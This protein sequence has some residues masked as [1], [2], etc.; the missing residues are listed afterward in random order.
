MGSSAPPPVSPTM[1]SAGPP[2][3]ETVVL[4]GG[5]SALTVPAVNTAF[6]TVEVCVHGTTNCQKI[7]HVEIDTGS[8]GLR[9]IA[10]G[11]SDGELSLAL[12]AETNGST[13]LA[14]CL[15][16]ADGTS[17][18]ALRTADVTL[19][20][21]GETASNVNVQVIGDPAAGSPPSSCAGTAEN[22]VQTFGANGILGIGPFINDCNSFGACG[23]GYSAI[24]YSC[25]ASAGCSTP[26]SATLAQQLQNPVTLFAKDNNGVILELPAIS[27]SG[28][29]NPSGVLVF[30]INTES[31]NS[32][33]SATQLL[34]NTSTGYITA[35]LN[36]TT[37]TDSYLDS[38]SNGN[39]FTDSS[40]PVCP[41]PNNG[42]YCPTA[43]TSQNAM[44]SSPTS[45]KTSAADFD[46]ANAS[47][48]FQANP[49]YTVFTQLAGPN[50]DPKSLDLGLAFFFGHFVYTAIE[51]PTTNTPPYFAF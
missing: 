18:G 8:V 41:M 2:N 21:S 6:V 36:G 44:L 1:A 10:A 46:I 50:T 16:F 38:G 30:G 5:P 25:S 23:G 51:N 33:G 3:V 42:F 39:F 45:G 31:N 14:E 11:N 17:W 29:T 15:E 49:T 37:Y 19:P 4:D 22:T 13:P 26:Y 20:I 7:D 12:P 27:G 47:S 9:L 34:A 48:L 28:A 24:Y 32:L 40:L 35:T 43:T